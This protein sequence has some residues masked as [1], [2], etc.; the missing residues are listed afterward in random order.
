MKNKYE[1]LLAGI[2]S[3]RATSFI[4]SK[5][6]LQ[7]MDKFNLLGIRFLLAFVL[8]A[9]LFHKELRRLTKEAFFS[10]VLIGLC[11]Y[12]TMSCEMAALKQADSSMVSLL[13]NCAI[14]FVP[15]IKAVLSRTIPSRV[16]ILSSM[17]AMTGV[18]LLALHHG[19]LGG[20]F[21]FGL[22]AALCYAMAILVTAKL[23]QGSS[24]TLGIG[25]IQVG[26]IGT[27]S[28]ISSFVIEQPT[29]PQTGSQWLMLL[30]LVL[31]C[32]G[33][34]FTLQPVAQS[35]VS[36]ERAGL[37]C[38]IN[39]AIAALLGVVILKEQLGVSGFFGIL[40]ILGS[41]MLPHILEPKT[42]EE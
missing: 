10:G 15:L 34:G 27:L 33:F 38:A 25:I 36:A 29:L 17:V 7:S 4:F 9:L 5:M 20:G 16:T 11:F 35:H 8:L 1:L 31:V 6:I 24:R 32:T 13:E 40:L 22:L 21:S 37:F 19:N 39:P 3:A 41:L 23:T 30:M 28:M 26:T 18:V 42:S 12:L 14:I 2:I